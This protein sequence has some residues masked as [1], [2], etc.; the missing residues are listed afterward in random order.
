MLLQSSRRTLTHSTIGTAP[1]HHGEILQGALRRDGGL[2]RCLVTMPHRGV[3]SVAHYTRCAGHPLKVRPAWKTKAL[4][5]ARLTLLELQ[6][7]AEGVL[8]IECALPVGLGRGSSTADVVAAIRAVCAG[9]DTALEATRVARIAVA[10]E[11]AADPLMFEDQ[12]LLF[13]QREGVV[14]ESWGSWFPAFEVLSVDMDPGRGGI[15]TLSLTPPDYSDHEISHLEDLTRQARDA[16]QR[17]DRAAVAAIAT[18]SAALNQRFMPMKA[19]PAIRALGMCS[20]ALGVQIAHSG[21]LAGILFEP[22][23]V[24]LRGESFDRLVTELNGLGAHVLGRFATCA[25]PAQQCPL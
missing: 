22:D 16:F 7:V 9:Y 24:C 19:F 8:E 14:L 25:V 5:A 12:M 18:A 23:P 17:Q 11:S 4:Q 15:D 10:A 21:T 6:E 20:D 3:G 2:V 1:S 13:A